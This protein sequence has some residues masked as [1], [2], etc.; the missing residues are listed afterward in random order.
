MT[1]VV[2][3]GNG[4]PQAEHLAAGYAAEALG[5]RVVSEWL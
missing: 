4:G 2:I 5:Q 1:D 3:A